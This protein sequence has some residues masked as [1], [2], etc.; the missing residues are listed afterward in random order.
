MP[1]APTAPGRIAV[2][3]RQ[4]RLFFGSKTLFAKLQL[5]KEV[6]TKKGKLAGSATA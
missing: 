5:V 1:G 4:F 3:L 6:W 2:E